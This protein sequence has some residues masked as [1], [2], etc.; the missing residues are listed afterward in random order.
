MDKI[1]DFYKREGVISIAQT[2]DSIVSPKSIEA[3]KN[4]VKKY[5]YKDILS[6]QVTIKAEAVSEINIILEPLGIEVTDLTFINIVIPRG[7][8]DKIEELELLSE[9]LE[10]EQQRLAEAKLVTQTELEFANREKQKSII[11]AEGIAE[12]NRITSEQ[13]L[14]DNILEL[15]KLEIQKSLIEKWDGVTPTSTGDNFSIINQ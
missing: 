7:Y 1:F 14:T 12:A 6:Q 13:V 8:V 4:V 11:E 5:S 2:T 10:I 15:K 3:I 9:S